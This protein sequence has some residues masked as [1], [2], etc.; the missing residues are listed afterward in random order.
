MAAT[1][2]DDPSIPAPTSLVDVLSG[3][4][5]YLY[6]L[7]RLQRNGLIP[8]LNALANVTLLAPVNSAFAY[9]DSNVFASENDFDRYVIDLVVVVGSLPNSTLV[10]TTLNSKQH[11]V[12]VSPNFDDKEYVIDE[13]AAIVEED[14]YAKHQRS[15]VQAIDHL[16]PLK[17]SLCELLINSSIEEVHGKSIRIAKQLFQLLFAPT[18]RK[19][20][21][22]GSCSNFFGKAST[23]FLPSDEAFGSLPPLLVTY[24]TSLYESMTNPA[25]NTKKEA[26]RELQLDVATFLRHWVVRPP[27]IGVNGTNA[28][29]FSVSGEV[30]YKP[31]LSGQNIVVNGVLVALSSVLA[32]GIVHVISDVDYFSKLHIPTVSLVPRKALYGLHYSNFVREMLFRKLHHLIDGSTTD[33]TVFLEAAL[34]DDISEEVRDVGAS[35]FGARQSILY[36]FANEALEFDFPQNSTLN[37]LVNTNL[38]SKSKLG[39]CYRVKVS[40]SYNETGHIHVTLNDDIDVILP[41]YVAEGTVI[42]ITDDELDTPPSLKHALGT[43]ISNGA[44]P[45]HLEHIEIDKRACLDTI[46][47]LRKN[48]LFSLADSGHGFTAFLPCAKRTSRG[49]NAWN[50]LGLVLNHLES[51]PHHFKRVLEGLFL[52]DL[53]YSDFGLDDDADTELVTKNLNGEKVKVVESFYDGDTSHLVRV[54]DTLLLIPLNSDVLFNQGVVHIVDRVVLPDEFAVSLGDLIATTDDPLYKAF[55]IRKLLDAAPHVRHALNLDGV[56]NTPYSIL[57]PTP[58]SLQDF[59]ITTEFS[60]LVRFLQF[61]L[62]PNSELPHLLECV[63]FVHGLGPIATNLTGVHIE[64]GHDLAHTKAYIHLRNDFVAQGY[65]KD[66]EVK[67]LN[68]G[69]TSFGD[70]ASCVFLIDKPLSL[71]WLEKNNDGFLHVHLGFVSVGLGII[72]GVLLFGGVVLSVAVCFSKPKKATKVDS[73]DYNPLPRAGPSFMRVT[74]DDTTPHTPYDG[75]YETD[76]DMLRAELERLLP[77]G[78]KKRGTNYGAT[79]RSPSAPRVIKANKLYQRDVNFPNF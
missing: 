57:V 17:P 61:H 67:V 48:G 41:P 24:Y 52:K 20:E 33:Q 66:H 75:G 39:L 58:E 27:I 19:F 64:C 62:I 50:Q 74:S 51:H 49:P 34:R 18:S 7:R 29:H 45:R 71:Q 14:V 35:S 65:N 55:S 79:H 32:D 28:S 30:N 4:I 53:V 37:R 77:T 72:L 63:N 69:C 44:V 38:C 54:N 22:M 21:G 12:D 60:Q 42:Y 3:D 46:G 11:Y 73:I 10:Y 1:T 40:A 16:L 5:Q 31:V 47:Y 43:L 25:Y 15:Y 6:F 8:Q 13:V 68:H 56:G 78:R 36:K 23:L 59:N 2:L 26:I 9:D 70:N 76:D